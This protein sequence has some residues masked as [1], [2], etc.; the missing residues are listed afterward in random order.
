M[1]G[2]GF[3]SSDAF[4]EL[5]RQQANHLFAT[6]IQFC[7]D[8]L[9]LH[10]NLNGSADFRARLRLGFDGEADFD[11]H[12]PV[13]QFSFVNISA[14]FD[15][16]EPA[17]VL[18]RFVRAFNGLINGVLDGCGRGTGEFNE[19]IDVVFHVRLLQYACSRTSECPLSAATSGGA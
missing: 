4:L 1:L 9:F 11:G 6:D 12:L 18:D 16:L 13:I 7:G 8:V 5:P 10:N 17:Q 14:R 2:K 19:F 3:H 15:Y